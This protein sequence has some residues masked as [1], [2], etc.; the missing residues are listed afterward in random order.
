MALCELPAVSSNKKKTK[1]NGLSGARTI[2]NGGEKG[3]R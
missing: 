1:R 2:L 3:N